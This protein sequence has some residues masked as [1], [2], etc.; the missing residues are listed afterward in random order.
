L[1]SA[2]NEI[3][4]G[5]CDDGDFRINPDCQAWVRQ[6]ATFVVARLGE[7]PRFRIFVY[8]AGYT[9]LAID[10]YNRVTDD[11]MCIT[12]ALTESAIFL[13]GPAGDQFD[14]ALP[15]IIDAL[16]LAGSLLSFTRGKTKAAEE[17]WLS[18]PDEQGG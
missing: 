14:I 10:A 9:H 16:H 4:F 5:G 13:C 1:P 6:L 3:Q 2:W 7:L 12:V 17:L 18:Y 8:V 15:G 11:A